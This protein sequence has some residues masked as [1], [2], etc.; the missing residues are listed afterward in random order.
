[1]FTPPHL[2]E[3]RQRKQ[4]LDS[5]G[6]MNPGKVYRSPVILNPFIFTAGMEV[7]AAVRRVAGRSGHR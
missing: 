1:M 6:I 2:N 7:L 3:L 4:M 5:R